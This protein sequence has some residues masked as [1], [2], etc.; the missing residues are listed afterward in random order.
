[1][2]KIIKQLIEGGFIGQAVIASL[3]VGGYVIMS[4]AKVDITKEYV[5]MTSFVVAWYFRSQAQNIA[6]KKA[7]K[8]AKVPW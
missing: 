6:D 1:M 7:E 2:V 5:A 8:Y 4:I 3:L